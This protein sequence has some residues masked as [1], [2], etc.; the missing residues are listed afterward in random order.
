MNSG[1]PAPAF[2]TVAECRAWM[3]GASFSDLGQ[4]QAM[5]LVQAQRLAREPLAAEERLAIFEVLRGPIYELQE[6]L[7]RRYAGKS[8]PLAPAEQRTFDSCRELW[9][10]L[11]AGYMRCAEGCFTGDAAMQAKAALPLQ[12]A[13]AALA[14]EQLET[15][16]AGRTPP[17]SHWRTLHQIYES[18]EQLGV[19]AEHVVD[20]ERPGDAGSV[21]ATYAECMLLAAASLHEHSQRQ[22]A[23]VARWARLWAPKIRLLGAPPTLST[24]AIPL[25]VDLGSERPG[26]YAPLSAPGA[27]WLDTAELQ[28]SIRKRLAGLEKGE[29]PARL[30]LGDDCVQPACEQVLKRVYQRWCKGAAIRGFE[31]R[32][33]NGDCRLIV[34]A[35]AIHY[36][37]SG[38]TPFRDTAAADMGALRKER[39]QIA[40]FGEVK[41]GRPEN[42]SEQHGYGVEQWQ[43][44]ENWHLV[45]ISVAG[46]RVSRPAGANGS[47]IAQGLLVAA[48]PADARDF[49]LGSIR[50]ALADD[51]LQAGVHLLAGRPE[52]VSLRGAD[53][54]TAEKY[55]QAFLLPATPAVQ[56][57]AC[58]VMPVGSFKI[59]REVEVLQ[60]AATRRL[61]L[62]KLI[63]RG[64][65]FERATYETG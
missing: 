51:S 9:H 42:F 8:L 39:E 52:P 53:A 5:V 22:L 45:D 16:R 34:G 46:M 10:A 41:T 29:A 62:L 15:H 19:T 47:R 40:T 38:R 54:P 50:W 4:A 37:L 24:R 25:C 6:E 48:R 65:D 32:P 30:G 63:E 59:G 58:I 18:A 43:L 23:W 11:A 26:S 17:P 12:R 56:Q 28:R 33:A 3:D 49:L 57:E 21:A 27:R 20:T 31:R 61:R 64:A 14:A 7:A 44:E 2:H 55:R 35:E 1:S 13:L 36:Y 60:G